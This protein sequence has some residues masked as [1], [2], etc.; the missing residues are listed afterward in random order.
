V[1][2]RPTGQTSVSGSAVQTR[3]CA[4]A[5]DLACYLHGERFDSS[6]PERWDL[7]RC[8]AMVGLAAAC[9]LTGCHDECEVGHASC[10][11]NDLVTCKVA[12]CH[13]PSCAFD[14]DTRWSTTTCAGVCV[15]SL[16][17]PAFCALSNDRD[18]M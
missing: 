1:A 18:P 2:Y 15:D 5:A 17:A 12:G 16:D 11:G 9:L 14:A 8:A 10:E 4:P 6:A 13:D 7:G 3:R